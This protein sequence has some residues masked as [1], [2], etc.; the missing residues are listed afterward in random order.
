[1]S[2]AVVLSDRTDDVSGVLVMLTDK[3]EAEQIA[4]EMRRA[5]HQVEVRRVSDS[6]SGRAFSPE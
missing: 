4:I 5:G 2:Y 6:L 1:M 3:G